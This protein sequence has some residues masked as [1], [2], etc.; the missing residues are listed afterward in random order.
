MKIYCKILLI[1]VCFFVS[2]HS[3]VYS[4]LLSSFIV[5][6]RIV[7]FKFYFDIILM[8]EYLSVRCDVNANQANAQV[9]KYTRQNG[10]SGITL[11]L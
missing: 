4:I 7:N 3:L 5:S 6:I 9:M 1:V 2:V 11:D 10:T 8:F